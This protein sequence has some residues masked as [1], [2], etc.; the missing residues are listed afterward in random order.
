MDTE[1]QFEE[2][3]PDCKVYFDGNAFIAVPKTHK[4]SN[5]A[6]QSVRSLL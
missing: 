4:E 2:W 5:V 3:Y 1:K 6:N